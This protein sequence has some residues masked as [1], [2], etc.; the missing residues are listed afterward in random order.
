MYFTALDVDSLGR[1]VN[2][3][4]KLNLITQKPEWDMNVYWQN[5]DLRFSSGQVWP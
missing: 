3:V 1:R 2:Q 4:G 5:P